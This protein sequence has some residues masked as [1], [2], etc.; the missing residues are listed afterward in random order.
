MIFT[1]FEV[2]V[3]DYVNSPGL[4]AGLS[5]WVMDAFG[6]THVVNLHSHLS[7]VNSLYPL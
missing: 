2:I 5:L 4:H 1:L 7:K 3:K 6:K